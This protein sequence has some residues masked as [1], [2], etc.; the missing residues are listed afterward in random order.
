MFIEFK[1]EIVKIITARYSRTLECDSKKLA[2]AI[3]SII[4]LEATPSRDKSQIINLLIP[5]KY[6][7]V[8]TC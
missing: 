8:I 4:A 3:K 1:R 5:V 6:K 2:F 7:Y